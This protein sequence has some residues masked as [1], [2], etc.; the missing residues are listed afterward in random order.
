MTAEELHFEVYT[1]SF[2]LNFVQQTAMDIC[3]RG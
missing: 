1:F 3:T 2:T